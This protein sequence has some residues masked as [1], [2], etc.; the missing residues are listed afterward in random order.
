MGKWQTKEVV[1]FDSYY[2]N[3]D[4]DCLDDCKDSMVVTFLRCDESCH[5][6]ERTWFHRWTGANMLLY[7]ITDWM[8]LVPLFVCMIFAGIGF[9]QLVMRKSFFKVDSDILVLGVYYVVVIIC[10]LLFEAIPINYRY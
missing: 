9:Y 7:T 10:Y 8:G 1:L 6:G 4:V 2:F 5:R 3:L